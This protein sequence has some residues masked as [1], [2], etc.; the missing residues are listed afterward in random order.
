MQVHSIF[1]EKKKKKHKSIRLR[2][3]DFTY[4]KMTLL[5]DYKYICIIWGVEEYIIWKRILLHLE[6]KKK[7]VE[8]E[9]VRTGSRLLCAYFNTDENA[10]EEPCVCMQSIYTK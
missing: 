6:N 5:G 1:F 10:R 3:H 8:N 7:I 4:N 2:Q 9:I